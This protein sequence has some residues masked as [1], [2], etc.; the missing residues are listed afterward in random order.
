MPFQKK[1][2]CC[3]KLDGERFYKPQGKKMSSL[4]KTIINL[5]EL[6]A[7]RLC[8]SL[9]LSQKEAADK[10]EI[11]TGTIQRLV[12]SARKKFIDSIYE[13]HAIELHIPDNI[14]FIE[15]E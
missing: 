2:R 1:R 10:M 14:K 3:Q 15:K 8:D 5:D 9:N 11:S 12:Y 7:M 13:E 6:E 4:K